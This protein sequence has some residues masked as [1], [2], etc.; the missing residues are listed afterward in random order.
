MI[1]DWIIDSIGVAREDVS[2]TVDVHLLGT[3]HWIWKVGAS[4]ESFFFIGGG[5]GEGGLIAATVSFG[6]SGIRGI[7][8]DPAFSLDG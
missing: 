7:L 5:A 6:F 1:I 8:N 2:F 3:F 4:A